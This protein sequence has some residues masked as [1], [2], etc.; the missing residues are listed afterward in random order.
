MVH[1][2][3]TTLLA[4]WLPSYL[5]TCH[6]ADLRWRLKLDMSDNSMWING[7][8]VWGREKSL[9]CLKSLEKDPWLQH[10]RGFPLYWKFRCTWA[11]QTGRTSKG[12]LQ[13]SEYLNPGPH[14]R[15]TSATCSS[16]NS[17]V[18]SAL[19]LA[20]P[21]VSPSCQH[22]G[23][24]TPPSDAGPLASPPHWSERTVKLSL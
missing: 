24:T 21:A 23:S 9:P 19:P 20:P 3:V 2:F 5:A 18:F 13:G 14:F 6:N 22:C 17:Q 15:C 12:G 7:A 8:N 10:L 11:A 16:N 4:T 1:N